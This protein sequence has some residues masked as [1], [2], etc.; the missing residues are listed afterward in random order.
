MART[1]SQPRDRRDVDYDDRE[2]KRP[3]NSRGSS[4]LFWF[5]SR[6]L[7]AFVLLATLAFF[8]PL[9]IGGTGLWKTILAVASPQLAGKIDAASLQ[10]FWLSPVEIRNLVVR[11]PAGQPMVQAALV[12][13]HKTLLE[14]AL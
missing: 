12:R 14:L 13:S 1:H 8:A 7:V 5:G 11:D 9:L 4:R 2:A 3:V 10:L 6:L